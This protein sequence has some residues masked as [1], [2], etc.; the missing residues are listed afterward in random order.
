LFVPH[1]TLSTAQRV[2]LIDE[3]K[4][5]RYLDDRG[6][7]DWTRDP[8]IEQ[9]FAVQEKEP[10]ARSGTWRLISRSYGKRST[11]ASTYHDILE[12]CLFAGRGH[13]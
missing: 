11:K 5:A 1:K 10:T 4:Y 7:W 13:Q 2:R 9:D 3:L 12:R 8:V 6:W